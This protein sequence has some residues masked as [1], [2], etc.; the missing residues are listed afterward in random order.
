MYI[1]DTANMQL[2]IWMQIH[3]NNG[4]IIKLEDRLKLNLSEMQIPIKSISASTN[5]T[6]KFEKVFEYL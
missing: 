4:F 5:V 2:Q 3:V 6:L 1:S